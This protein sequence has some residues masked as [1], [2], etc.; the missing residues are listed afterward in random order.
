MLHA[1]GP[2]RWTAVV[3]FSIAM[4]AGSGTPASATG[5]GG[6]D[7]LG[8]GATPSSAALDGRVDALVSVSHFGAIPDS[9]YAGGVFTSAGGNTSA[10]MIARWDGSA[11]HSIGAPPISTADGAGVRAIAVDRV[12]GKVYVG[13]N[14]INAGGNPNADFLAVWDGVSWKSFC[15]PITANVSALQI[16]GRDALHRRGLCRRRRACRPRTSSCACDMDTGIASVHGGRRGP[17]DQQLDLR[18]DRRLRRPPVCRGDVRQHGPD[19]ERRPRRDVRR[20]WHAM[21]AGAVDNITRSIASD[22]TNVYIGSDS[23]DIAGI[24]QADHVAKWNGSAWSALGANAAR[25]RRVAPGL[26]VHQRAG[27]Q[28]GPTCSSRAPSRT[29][30]GIPPPT[31]SPGST[32]S[33]GRRLG[34]DGAGNGPLPGPG[35]A[36]AVFGGQVVVGGNFITA[37]GDARA[38]YIARYPGAAHPLT[39]VISSQTAASP[40][41]SDPRPPSTARERRR[42]ADRRLPLELQRRL[43]GRH[44][45]ADRPHADQAGDEHRHADRD[46]QLWHGRPRPAKTSSSPASTHRRG[47]RGLP[48]PCSPETRSRST[49]PP[50]PT[51]TERSPPTTG[52]GATA[53][54]TPR[55]P[56]RRTRSPRPGPTRSLCSCTTTTPSPGAAIHPVTVVPL[57]PP[58]FSHASLSHAS[59]RVGSKQT[60][61]AAKAPVGT[62]FRFTLKAPARVAVAISRSRRGHRGPKAGTLKRSHLHNGPNAIA[63]SGRIGRR[64]LKPGKYLATLTASNAKGK[65]KPVTVRFTIVR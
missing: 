6:W 55:Q 60:A 52:N 44:R 47:S 65:A 57:V 10:T 59:F 18:A 28:P 29:P 22:G 1:A 64:A 33:A 45:P 49:G 2:G 53:T 23:V 58:A 21:Q 30:T 54:P 40:R 61:V 38:S 14:F 25:T 51:P 63:F 4:L 26:G 16:I 31:R 46:R 35:N 36:I 50:P 9:V 5:P 20:H 56:S 37:G 13:G 48:H 3:A 15:A 8:T 34:S 27:R 11:W 43:A 19:P 62:S 24:A 42:R 32:A 7:H 41:S 12:T 17:R 39:A